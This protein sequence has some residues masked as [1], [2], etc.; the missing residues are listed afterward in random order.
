MSLLR[1]Q[2]EREHAL[3]E[4]GDG[5]EDTL[6]RHAGPVHAE[7]HLL[8]AQALPVQLDLLDTVGGV[9]DD[10]AVL[11]ELLDRHPKGLAGGQHVVLTPL[12]VG[13]VLDADVRQGFA[14]G[15][16][17]VP[18]DVEWPVPFSRG[19]VAPRVGVPILAPT[20]GLRC[21]LTAWGSGGRMAIVAEGRDL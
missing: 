6:M 12:S 10:E 3:A 4:E 21:S 14:Q 5:L 8:D 16:V 15:G 20:P 19:A 18:R 9:V 2:K 1:L 7:P 13:L 11:A 17:H